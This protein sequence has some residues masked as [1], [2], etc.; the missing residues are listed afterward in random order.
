[1]ASRFAPLVGAL[2]LPLAAVSESG[3]LLILFTKQ[4]TT[5]L[6]ALY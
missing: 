2:E 1:M 4:D 3:N 6:T 5:L